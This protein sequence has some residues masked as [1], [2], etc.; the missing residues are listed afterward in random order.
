MAVISFALSL[1]LLLL[2][3]F[4]FFFVSVQD[5]AMELPRIYRAKYENL[6]HFL[7]I[8]FPAVVLLQETRLN[9][10]EPRPPNG[11]C[12]Y[13]AFRTPVPGYGLVTLFRR[14]IPMLSCTCRPLYRHFLL[15]HVFLVNTL[16]ATLYISPNQVLAMLDIVSPWLCGL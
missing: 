5:I 9:D 14:D 16:Y 1:H 10:T 11:Y 8:E 15:E 13:S 2:Y 12:L 3:I 7:H 4:D 6:C